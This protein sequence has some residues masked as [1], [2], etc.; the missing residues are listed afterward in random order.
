MGGGTGLV[1][2][3]SMLQQCTQGILGDS[4][5]GCWQAGQLS[6]GMDGNPAAGETDG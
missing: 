1:A 4:Y 2:G 3:H 5:S 6:S